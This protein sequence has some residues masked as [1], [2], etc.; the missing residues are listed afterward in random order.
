M[1]HVTPIAGPTI[2]LSV[3]AITAIEPT[4]QPV[5]V[6]TDGRRL[7]VTDDPSDLVRRIVAQ[8]AVQLAGAVAPAGPTGTLVGAADDFTGA[9]R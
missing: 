7:V 2:L 1:V 8:R 6:L 9:A 3:D 4:P 5:V